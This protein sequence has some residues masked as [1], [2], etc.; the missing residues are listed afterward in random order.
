VTGGSWTLSGVSGLQG[1]ESI[2][3]TAGTGAATSANSAAVIVT[4]AAPAMNG[5]LVEGQTAVTGAS[6]APAGSTITVY[7]DGIPYTATVQPGGTW[8]VT[9][10]PLNAGA[11]VSSTVTAG[12][13]TSA[14]SGSQTVTY[15]APSLN[16]PVYPID[17]TISGTSLSAPGTTITVYVNGLPIGTTTIQPGGTWS[18]GGV[19]GL[20][21]GDIITATTGTGAATSTLSAPVTV[22]GLPG[23][24][25]NA[26]LGTLNP[27]VAQKNAI[28]PRRPGD[29]SLGTGDRVVFLFAPAASYP[30]E[31]TDY[32]D[33]STP[34]TFFQLESNPG[35]TLRVHKDNLNG[36]LV[37]TY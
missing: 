18:L 20:N 30:Q 34:I 8:S 32:T 33:Q 35:N 6:T 26:A 29:P 5:P 11:I 15:L 22:A 25:R 27:S 36:K 19:S 28:F 3:A 4:P 7:V 24:L 10:P 17:T 16:N 2:T 37:V 31:S 1:G 14:A 9:V 13:Q 23:L 12:G 21:G